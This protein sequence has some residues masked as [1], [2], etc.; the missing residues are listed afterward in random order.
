MRPSAAWSGARKLAAVVVVAAFWIV[1]SRLAN[2][3]YLPPLA[4]IL[5]AFKDHWFG[6]G[7]KGDLLPSVKRMFVGFMLGGLAGVTAG[8][9]LGG[10]WP[11]QK[12][13]EPVFHFARSIPGPV[14]VLMLLV[15]FGIGDQGKITA[16]GLT[17]F[18]PVVLNTIAGYRG[19][20]RGLRDVSVSF[21]LTKVQWFWFGLLPSVAPQ[22]AAGLRTSLSLSFIVMI[23]SEYIGA[24]NGIGY[25]TSTSASSFDFPQMWAGVLLLSVLGVGSNSV[26][27]MVERRVIFWTS[28]NTAR[29]LDV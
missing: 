24:T 16:I 27:Q 10:F 25:F 14:L 5:T 12:A 7:F 6:A 2:S 9:A 4:R 22:I 1:I 18:F 19:L 20:D 8:L 29:S 28:V 17:C 3:I 11:L 21:S 15:L 26:F 13:T 23:V